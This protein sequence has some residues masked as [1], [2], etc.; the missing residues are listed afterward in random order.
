MFICVYTQN[1]VII[2]K[3]EIVNLMIDFDDNK[4]LS[5]YSTKHMFQ[6]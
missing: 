3:E 1:F 6:K 4:I 5:N 2:K